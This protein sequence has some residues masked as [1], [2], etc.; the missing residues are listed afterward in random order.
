MLRFCCFCPRKPT[1]I[2]LLESFRVRDRDGDW[3]RTRSSGTCYEFSK[4]R[5]RS[6]QEGAWPSGVAQCSSKRGVVAQSSRGAGSLKGN[7][8]QRKERAFRSAVGVLALAECFAVGVLAVVEC[9]AV[10]VLALVECFALGLRTAF[11][12]VFALGTVK[13]PVT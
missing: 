9:F 5:H 10:G 7:Q 2:G 11:E 3:T 4:K 12:A 1:R 8:E 6:C 13:P